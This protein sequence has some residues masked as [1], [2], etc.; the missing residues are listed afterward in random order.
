MTRKFTNDKLVLATHNRGKIEEFKVML[1]GRGIELVSAGEVDL[2]EPEETGV[3]FF[4]N[5]RIKAVAGAKHCGLPCLADDSG[6]CVDAIEGNPGIYSARWGGPEKDFNKAMRLVHERM[7]DTENKAAA[8]VAVLVLAWPD[9]HTEHAEGRVDG[10]IA[11]PPR[12]EHGHGYDPIFVPDGE[13]RSFA[14]MTMDEKNAYSH[15]GRALDALIG[16]IF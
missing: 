16:K 7:G 6:L 4:E 3:T 10:Q 9:G 11:W 2:P 12:G 5:A 14:E 15:R 1:G 8:F 13:A